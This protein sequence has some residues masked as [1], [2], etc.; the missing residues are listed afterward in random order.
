MISILVVC[1]V[2]M[3]KLALRSKVLFSKFFLI[4]GSRSEAAVSSA[5]DSISLSC[6]SSSS[7]F[8]TSTEFSWMLE[9]ECVLLRLFT[10]GESFCSTRFFLTWIKTWRYRLKPFVKTT[11]TQLTCFRLTSWLPGGYGHGRCDLIRCIY[12]VTLIF[13]GKLCW[14]VTHF[15]YFCVLRD[16]FAYKSTL[17]K[18][19]LFPNNKNNNNNNKIQFTQV[20]YYEIWKKKKINKI[21][22]F[23]L[24]L[25]KFSNRRI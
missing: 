4:D 18:N 1:V 6:S 9:C 15:I 14:H 23:L 3:L 24:I 21:F 20:I 11:P 12:I 7:S 10:Y 8:L 17:T 16:F 13:S 19:L 5:S 2:L 22:F 25:Y